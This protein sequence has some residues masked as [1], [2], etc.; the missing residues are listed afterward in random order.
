MIQVFATFFYA[1]QAGFQKPRTRDKDVCKWGGA[2]PPHPP[3]FFCA[4]QAIFQENRTINKNCVKHVVVMAFFLSH[5]TGCLFAN[6]G[7]PA[8][9]AASVLSAFRFAHHVLG[10]RVAGVG[11]QSGLGAQQSNS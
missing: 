9:K 4:M 6:E 10:F 2:A 7:A 11:N 3:A 1:M 5:H 8:S